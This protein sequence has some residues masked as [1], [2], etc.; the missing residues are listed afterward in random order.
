MNQTTVERNN[1]KLNED[2][3]DVSELF[4]SIFHYRW[5]IL[6]ITSI[7]VLIAVCFLYF[8][9]NIYSSTAMIE[10]KS[11]AGGTTGGMPE[12]DFLGGALSGFGSS[13][14]NKDIEILKTFHV[15]NIVINKLN[16][17]IRYYVDKEFKRVEVYNN[18]P[19][20]VKNV[21]FT[22]RSIMGHMIKLTP[23][24][25]GYHLQVE[26]SFENK[27]RSSKGNKIDL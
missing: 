21:T 12:G 20:E 18:L 9:P 25:D 2:E 16:F 27:Y 6:L 26:N 7:T 10:V 4:N 24:K 8:K 3:I 1:R 14:V 22:D 15:N 17:H 19:V 23:A 11:S 13:N 5:S